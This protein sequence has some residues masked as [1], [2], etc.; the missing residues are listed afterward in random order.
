MSLLELLL[1]AVG[2]SMDAF[3]VAICKGLALRRVTPGRAAIVGLWF[4]GFQA[5]MPALGYF[6]GDRFAS[7]IS[8]YDHWIILVLLCLIGGNMIR[9]ALDKSEAEEET[10]P[11]LDFKSMLL[12]AIATS[13]DALAV[14]V[15]FAFLS[16]SILPSAALIGLTTFLLSAL[17]IC[18]GHAFGSRFKSGAELT[19][20]VILIL[21]GLK[22]LLEHLGIL[23]V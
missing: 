1:V 3:S 12:L 16:V 6:L 20:G 11:G 7:A 17:G 8:R 13:I 5:L 21:I 22:I 2:L 18:I 15:T 10:D 19:G 4:G 14:G 9:E 23:H